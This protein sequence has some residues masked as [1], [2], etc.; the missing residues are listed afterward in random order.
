[1]RTLPGLAMAHN[2]EVFLDFSLL[3]FPVLSQLDLHSI[4]LAE[5]LFLTSQ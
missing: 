3:V 1:M 5:H 2:A 4:L